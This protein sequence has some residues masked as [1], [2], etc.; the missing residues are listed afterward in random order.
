[1]FLAYDPGIAILWRF[2]CFPYRVV[3][4]LVTGAEG[5][6]GLPSRGVRPTV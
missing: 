6:E 1:M 4:A 2:I 3:S 5:K